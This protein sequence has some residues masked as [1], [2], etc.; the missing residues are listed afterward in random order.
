MK[1]ALCF[2]M[3]T[4]ESEV[5]IDLIISQRDGMGREVGRGFRIGNMCTPVV[6][7]CRCMSKPIQYC[8]VISL[9]LKKTKTSQAS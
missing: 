8:K 4:V 3:N 1:N 5:K 7:S 2:R 9:Q 6:D